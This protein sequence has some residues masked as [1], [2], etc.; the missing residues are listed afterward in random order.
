MIKEKF[1]EIVEEY[2][3]LMKSSISGPDCTNPSLCKGNCCGIQIDVPKIL[4]EE[5][6][7]RGYATRDDFIRS[8]IFSFKFRF[9]DEKAKCCLFDP[10]IN[11]CSIH[12]SG[13]KPPQCWIYPTK[14]NNKSKNISCKIT[15]GWKITN[16]KNTRRAK[17]LLERY[18]T[19]SAEEARKE[20]D[21]I[22]KRIQNSLHL[23]KNCNIIKDLQNNKP[24]EL[25]GFQDGWDRIYPL[26]AEGISL[27]LKKF[28]QNKSNQCKY[29][30]ENFLECPYIC[31]DIA[32]SLISFFK[33]HIYQLIEKRGIDP[34]GMYPLHALFEFFNN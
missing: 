32:T 15:D 27:Q 12:H 33:T 8:N 31:K 4:A 3:R 2:N 34:N 17:E 30:P 16:F 24:S 22:K 5:Y 18:N 13:I 14:F 10:D 6:I 7:K 19:Y 20:H 1:L 11:G 26:P 9:D 23:S 25:G 29:M 28:C 21:L